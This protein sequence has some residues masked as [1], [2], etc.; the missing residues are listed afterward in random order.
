MVN[1][2]EIYFCD[3]SPVVGSEQKG[4]RPVVIVSSDAINHHLTVST[5]LPLSSFK[6]G[7]RV[8]AS[9]VLLGTRETGLSKDS[10]AMVYQIRTLS[11][12]RFLNRAGMISDELQRNKIEEAMRDYFEL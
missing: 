1:K 8:Y 2:W 4:K 7:E 3:L 6:E 12:D 11:H 10:I 9:E 5:V